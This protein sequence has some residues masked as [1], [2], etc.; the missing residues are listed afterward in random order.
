MT[1]KKAS[2]KPEQ[3][4]GGSVPPGVKNPRGETY[5]EG[6]GKSGGHWG[7]NYRGGKALAP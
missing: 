2:Y 6:G 4:R 1:Y 5:G 7:G 3:H